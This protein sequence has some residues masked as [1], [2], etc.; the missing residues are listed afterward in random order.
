MIIM[1]DANSFPYY[2]GF[3]AWIVHGDNSMKI[4]QHNTSERNKR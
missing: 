2:F 1:P 4:S 3:T